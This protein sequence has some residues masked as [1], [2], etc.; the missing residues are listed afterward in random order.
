MNR[1]VVVFGVDDDVEL[2]NDEDEED[3]ELEDEEDDDDD[4]EDYEEELETQK[5]CTNTL[6]LAKSCTKLQPT[7]AMACS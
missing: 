4:E 6:A 5:I 2:D 3:D 1:N 7:L